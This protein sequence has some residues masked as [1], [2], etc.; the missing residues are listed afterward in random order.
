MKIV[1]ISDTHMR[2]I[3]SIP[4]GDVLV[5]SGDFAISRNTRRD[6]LEFADW[7]LSLPHKHKVFIP[8]NHDWVFEFDEESA[9]RALKGVHILINEHVIIEGVKFYG[10]PYQPIFYDWAFNKKYYELL[11]AFDKI[12]SDTDVL[13]THTPPYGILDEVARDNAGSVG[14]KALRNRVD[15]LNLSAHIFGHVHESYGIIEK[16]GTT[17]VNCS[18]CDLIYKATNKPIIINIKE[19]NE[20]E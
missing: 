17:F 9:R 8:G 4:E 20:K 7:F 18:L 12:P 19:T 15:S 10:T 11:E 6:L 16:R 5:H 14:C 3:D 1:C 13:I 2:N